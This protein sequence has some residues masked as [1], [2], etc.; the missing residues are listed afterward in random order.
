MRE[1]REGKGGRVKRKMPRKFQR[2]EGTGRRRVVKRKG[3]R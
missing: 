2:L 1:L 3:G